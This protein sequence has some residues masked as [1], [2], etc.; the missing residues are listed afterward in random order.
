M[1]GQHFRHYG[2]GSNF[3]CLPRNPTWAKVLSGPQSDGFIYGTEYEIPPY[4]FDSIGP[5][6]IN[7]YTKLLHNQNAPCAVCQT[8]N[9]ATVTMFPARPYCF[10]GWRLEYTGYLMSAHPKHNGRMDYVCVDKYP[11]TNTAGYR[12]ENGALIYNVESKCGSLPCKPYWNHWEIACSV[13]SKY[14]NFHGNIL[15]KKIIK[16]DTVTE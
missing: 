5:F 10:P 12:D 13:C 16:N 15:K 14:P 1:A 3:L 8:I 9:P 6:F 2:G 11:E 7:L 4:L